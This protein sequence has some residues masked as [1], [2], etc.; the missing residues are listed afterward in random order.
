MMHDDD[1]GDLSPQTL[2]LD[3]RVLMRNCPHNVVLSTPK[4]RVPMKC[5]AAGGGMPGHVS[6][7]LL[8]TSSA[9]LEG[10]KLHAHVSLS[11]YRS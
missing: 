6:T 7:L 5:N 11:I 8:G 9:G 2:E 10:R 1:C 3:R 4:R